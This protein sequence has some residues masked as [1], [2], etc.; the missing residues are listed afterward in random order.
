MFIIMYH[1]R[2]HVMMGSS[3]TAGLRNDG[4]DK[5]KSELLVDEFERGL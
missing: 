3:L 1:T 5:N 4:D 2:G